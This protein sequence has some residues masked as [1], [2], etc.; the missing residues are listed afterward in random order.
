M[1]RGKNW[2]PEEDAILIKNIKKLTTNEFCELI[3]TR[4][5]KSIERRI[6]YLRD[7][8]IIGYRSEATRK[9]AYLGRRKKKH[10]TWD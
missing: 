10:G 6:E 5:K 2:T 4:S 3:P 9:R 8:N 1:G 7:L